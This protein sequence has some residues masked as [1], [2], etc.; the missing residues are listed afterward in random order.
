MDQLLDKRL[1]N[2]IT[3]VYFYLGLL[4]LVI[5]PMM[6]LLNLVRGQHCG[7]STLPHLLKQVF[8]EFVLTTLD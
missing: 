5:E 8:L 3:D 2:H 1:K 4:E 7:Q 6:L